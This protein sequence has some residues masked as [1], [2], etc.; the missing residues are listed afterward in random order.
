MSKTRPEPAMA[1]ATG[2]LAHGSMAR[3]SGEAAGALFGLVV[4]AMTARY[5]GPAGKGT[6]SALSYL[7]ALMAPLCAF[8]LGEASQTLFGQGHVT[9]GRSVRAVSGLLAISTG[10][11]MI[12]LMGV[13]GAMF[14]S[15][16]SGLRLAIVAAALTLPL[17][18]YVTIFGILLDSAGQVVFVSIVRLCIAISTAVATIV[19]MYVLE[20]AITGALLAI[21][22]GWSVGLMLLVARLHRLRLGFMPRWDPGFLRQAIPLGIPTQLSY[23][24]IVASTRVDLLLVRV[25]AGSEEAGSYSVALTVGQVTTYA[26]I[27][28]A[29]AA[30]P[31]IASASQEQ[32]ARELVG[33]VCRTT[34]LTALIGAVALGVA[35]PVALPLTFGSDFAPAV[36]PALVLLVGGILWGAQWTACRAESAR[37][38]PAILLGSFGASLVV[39]LIADVALIPPFGILGAAVAALL[40]S[41]VG[42]GVVIAPGRSGGRVTPGAAG[43]LPTRSDVSHLASTL[44]G[45]LGR[46]RPP[47]DHSL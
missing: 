18:T 47:S 37:G 34:V 21:V 9:L 19:L 11:G 16:I 2:A 15:E 33:R 25:L 8:G 7:V 29:V 10:I 42:L 5:L 22:A 45:L 39:M 6:L 38:R 35:I 1:R 32:E 31:V 3:F 12:V 28:L 27:A 17:I 30:F 44:S 20:L 43:F 41:A 40:G 24:L 13:I 14:S 36:A 23:L 46:S 4:G 26:P